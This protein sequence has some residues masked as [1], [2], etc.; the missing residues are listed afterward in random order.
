M[1]LG[2]KE[3]RDHPRLGNIVLQI[4][5]LFLIIVLGLV[6]YIQVSPLASPWLERDQGVF[7]YIGNLLLQGGVP[8]RDIWDHKPPFIYFVNALGLAMGGRWGVFAIEAFSGILAAVIGYAGLRRYVGNRAAF[9]GG[10]FF[11][12]AQIS[13]MSRGNFSES[14]SPVLQSLTLFFFLHTLTG[15]KNWWRWL[16]IGIL[17]GIA[18]LFKQSMVG[19]WIALGFYLLAAWIFRWEKMAWKNIFWMAVGVVLPIAAVSIY[20]ALN[21]ALAAFWDNAFVYNFFYSNHSQTGFI[22]SWMEIFSYTTDQNP[23]YLIAWIVW[24]GL[25]YS[26]LT[27]LILRSKL[28]NT[29]WIGVPILFI[30]VT[31]IGSAISTTEVVTGFDWFAVY[32][33]L[34]ALAGMFSLLVGILWLS[35]SIQRWSAACTPATDSS[36]NPVWKL[37][38]IISSAW[39]IDLIL[40]SLSPW[41]F[42]HYFIPLSIT[43]ACLVALAYHRLHQWLTQNTCIHTA[44][45][46]G[47]S[48]AVTLA[49]VSSLSSVEIPVY[50]YQEAAVAFVDQETEPGDPVLFWGNEVGLNFLSQRTPGVLYAYQYP[51]YVSGYTTPERVV[52]LIDELQTNPPVMILDTQNPWAPF[53]EQ[54]SE[55]CIYPEGVITNNGEQLVPV[56]LDPLFAYLCAHYQLD[57]TANLTMRVY[58]YNP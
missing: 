17:G 14:Y 15:K 36:K 50:S 4:I 3:N 21:G 56:E 18:F 8:Y 9:L 25:V 43:T 51:L 22:H 11:Y 33:L 27:K 47:A 38:F 10:L 57:T 12:L 40:I 13:C 23:V 1:G 54:T 32:A 39:I 30:G 16:L 2:N 55:G 35:G 45:W 28:A 31:F 46:S 58:R 49:L 19:F 34:K 7:T 42:S 29:K 44:F 41:N 6:T 24:L 26:A 20:L 53:V 52:S 48:I 37:S 5:A